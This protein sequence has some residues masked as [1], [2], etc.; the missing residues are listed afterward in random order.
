MSK[1]SLSNMRSLGALT[2][3]Q[4]TFSY[5]PWE[6]SYIDTFD[7][8]DNASRPIKVGVRGNQIIRVLPRTE[9]YKNDSWLMDRSRFGYTLV[10]SQR[11]TTPFKRQSLANN[12]LVK[13]T[14]LN[15]QS[16]R[17]THTDATIGVTEAFNDGKVIDLLKR[18]T[19]ESIS[20]CNINKTLRCA[21]LKCHLYKLELSLQPLKPKYLIVL[22]NIDFI[23]LI[24]S[25]EALI[26]DITIPG[27]IYVKR[28]YMKDLSLYGFPYFGD[29]LEFDKFMK[30]HIA[31]PANLEY[32]SIFVFWNLDEEGTKVT[33]L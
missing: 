14:G 28:S 9:I 10:Y 31:I 27:R 3:K 29:I 15:R 33:K 11:L 19:I 25:V 7:F 18:G 8:L 5:R 26:K 2:S 12:S 24:E 30:H 23:T 17:L 16:I 32:A 22:L 1:H 21:M 4:Y 20:L 6:L 13:M